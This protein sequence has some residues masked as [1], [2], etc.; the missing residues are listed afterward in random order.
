MVSNP[1]AIH[2]LYLALCQLK[3]HQKI[4]SEWYFCCACFSAMH[5]F[6]GKL[7][8]TWQ[9]ES[10]PFA[11]SLHGKGHPNNSLN[12]RNSLRKGQ[13]EEW[14][15]MKKVNRNSLVDH[16]HCATYWWHLATLF[17]QA[18]SKQPGLAWQLSESTGDVKGSPRHRVASWNKHSE[19]G[20]QMWRCLQAETSHCAN[21][22][23]F[24]LC[25]IFYK[26][27]CLGIHPSLTSMFDE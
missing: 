11:G 22:D 8:F 23:A 14:K 1:K 9:C 5:G 2:I 18:V 6:P 12:G 20:W 25:G 16:L 24:W 21:V 15:E 17:L 27:V 19:A 13:P 4:C 26:S 7:Q 10:H 3:I